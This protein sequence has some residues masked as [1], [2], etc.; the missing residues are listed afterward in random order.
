M[1]TDRPDVPLNMAVR[2]M[3]AVVLTAIV[4]ASCLATFYYF[5]PILVFLMG[6]LSKAPGRGLP[7]RL[8]LFH[9]DRGAGPMKQRLEAFCRRG[10]RRR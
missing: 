2:T 1:R 4:A 6:Q 10:P 5:A 7:C 3:L 8:H 9:C